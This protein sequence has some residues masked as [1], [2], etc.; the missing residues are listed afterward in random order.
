MRYLERFLI[1]R[2][3]QVIFQHLEELLA[4][5]LLANASIAVDQTGV[6]EMVGELIRKGSCLLQTRTA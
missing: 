1:G 6:G 4:N 5:S 2:S 3:Y